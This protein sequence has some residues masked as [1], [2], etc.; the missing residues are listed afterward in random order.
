MKPLDGIKVIE[1]SNWISGPICATIL[2]DCGAE[3]IKIEHLQTGGDPARGWVPVRLPTEKQIN[4]VFEAI[5]RGKRSLALDLGLEKGQE[6]FQRLIK[7]ADIL[8]TNLRIP[9]AESLK[10]DYET[11]SALNPRLIYARITGYGT[12]GPDKDRM[13]FDGLSFWARSGLMT[14]FS[15]PEGP[16][17]PLGCSLGDVTTGTYLSAGIMMAMYNRERTGKGSLVDTSLY[18]SG[19]WTS[20]EAIWA[21]LIGG[22]AMPKLSKENRPNPLL[23]YYQCSDGKWLNLS[24]LQSDRY[25]S[26]F[27]SVIDRPDL[28]TDPRFADQDARAENS[29]ALVA[30]ID[31]EI[32]KHP[33]EYWGPRLD[34]AHIAWGPISDI[35]EVAE[36]PQLQANDSIVEVEHPHLGRL[37]G[38]ATP[39]QINQETLSSHTAAPEFGSST[40]DILQ[41]HDYSWEE[42]VELKNQKVII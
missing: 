31:D 6:I 38:I 33:L 32:S 1:V 25:W 29:G 7:N 12:R 35:E 34:E 17:V 16:P 41:E 5:N 4:W 26:M 22:A 19:V 27:C 23:G 21:A 9:T 14:A 36:D 3:V 24:V 11:L 2:A 37:K 10:I 15:P 42:I 40:E 28:E 20:A 18:A 39:F 30:I 13:G 8:V